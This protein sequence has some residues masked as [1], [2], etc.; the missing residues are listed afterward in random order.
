MDYL[1]IWFHYRGDVDVRGLP[2]AEPTLLQRITEGSFSECPVYRAVSTV[3]PHVTTYV[4]H[5]CLCP[6]DFS[7]WSIIAQIVYQRQ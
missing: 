3:E 5:V 6:A 2:I 4:P 7:K 1:F